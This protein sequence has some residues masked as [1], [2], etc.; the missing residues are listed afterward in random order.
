MND[1]SAI[2][3]AL[4]YELAPF[5][6]T[7]FDDKGIM[8]ESKKSELYDVFTSSPF[9]LSD[10]TDCL[11][12]V[13]GGFLL[14]KVV[15]KDKK[16]FGDIINDYK[17]FI[18]NHYNN[19][20]SIIFD[21]YDESF[22]RVK[23]Y[24]RFRRMSKKVA[25]EITFELDMK[26]TEKKDLFL[27]NG[28]NKSRFISKLKSML[29]NDT[30]LTIKQAKED[31]D[32]YIIQTAIEL[33]EKNPDKKVVVIGTDVDLA[34]LLIALTP[35][36]LNITMWKPRASTKQP[37][38]IYETLNNQSLKNIILFAH[39][40]TGC[41]TTSAIFGKGKKKLLDT[42]TKNSQLMQYVEVFYNPNA[43]LTDIEVAGEQMMLSLYGLIGT[44]LTASQCRVSQVLN[45]IK[46][47][48]TAINLANL[49]PTSAAVRLHSYRVYYQV[50]IWLNNKSLNPENFG[51]IKSETMYLP[52]KTTEIL[53]PEK[54]LKLIHC[55]CIKDCSNRCGCKKA[56]LPCSSLC[57]NCKGGSCSN[58]TRPSIDDDNHD[59]DVH[60]S[61]SPA[62]NLNS[63]EVEYDMD[64]YPDF[65]MGLGEFCEP[66][67]EEGNEVLEETA[68]QEMI[69]ET[70]DD[71]TPPRKR[72]KRVQKSN[73]K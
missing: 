13:D 36:N 59:A 28:K 61:Q 62:A 30:N 21:G 1:T 40:F 44:D 60:S 25:P 47:S 69:A 66:I 35:E 42:V 27:A 55:S 19:T 29:I 7:L 20:T 15:W 51:W 26:L 9:R 46:K 50:Q 72:S 24:E 67:L 58:S 56:G 41:D 33:A 32:T 37:D 23:S 43:S 65:E 5:P 22:R 52:Q 3:T 8:R 54:L 18:F 38:M 57:K 4:T 73:K 14:H 2:K 11:F 71:E 48:K 34:A 16:T 68:A 64:N 63:D 70:P 12:V 10:F 6:M 49:P 45:T 53:A 31:A 17:T 39:A